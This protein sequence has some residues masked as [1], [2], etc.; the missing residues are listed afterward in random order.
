MR[1]GDGRNVLVMDGEW[2]GALVVGQTEF[3]S[4]SASLPCLRRPLLVTVHA[5]DTVPF[6][7][8]T[9]AICCHISWTRGAGEPEVDR[10]WVGLRSRGLLFL[11]AVPVQL[12]RTSVPRTKKAAGDALFWLLHPTRLL[13]LSPSAASTSAMTSTKALLQPRSPPQ[14]KT[15]YSR[16]SP[17]SS[18]QLRLFL[19]LLTVRPGDSLFTKE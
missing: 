3:I 13:W 2:H 17:L 16:V 14:T 4:C 15:L 19:I 11:P 5:P 7:P 6:D 18:L 8:W 12:G 1:I 9:R 10:G